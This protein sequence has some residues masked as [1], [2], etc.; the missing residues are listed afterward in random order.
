MR[1]FNT[2]WVMIGLLVVGYGYYASATMPD[3][4]TMGPRLAATNLIILGGILVLQGVLGYFRRARNGE[5]V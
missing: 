2:L 5:T 1:L 3:G 4:P